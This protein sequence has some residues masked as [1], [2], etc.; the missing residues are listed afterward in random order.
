MPHAEA[1]VANVTVHSG[2]LHGVFVRFGACPTYD[3]DADEAQCTGLCEVHWLTRWD[4]I[5]GERVS[6]TT[7][8]VLVPM[9]E[10]H[11]ES[12][13]RRAGVWYI[14]V[15]ALPAEAADFSLAIGTASPPPLVE[16]AYCGGL[17]RFCAS[18]TQRG[19]D[20]PLTTAADIRR[21]PLD[22]RS[23]ASRR[24]APSA[25]LA[26]AAAATLGALLLLPP[27]L[28]GRRARTQ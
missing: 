15:K 3:A 19:A 23:A 8:A 17:S 27:P 13:E 28:R 21:P 16:P 2:A 6:E 14:G 20:A 1:L 22:I 12:D 5:S 11:T 7:G 25:A 10:D 18:A 24:A 26:A 4:R 9:G